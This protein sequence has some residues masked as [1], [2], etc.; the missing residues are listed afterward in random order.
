MIPVRLAKSQVWCIRAILVDSG[1]MCYYGGMKPC[2]NTIAGRMWFAV[3]LIA[4]PA[5]C[6]VAAQPQPEMLELAGDLRVHDPV[7]RSTCSPLVV[8]RAEVSST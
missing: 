6:G 1:K 2:V 3:M 7:I 5:Y 8:D 4:G